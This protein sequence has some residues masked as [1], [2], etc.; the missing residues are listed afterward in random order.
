[1]QYDFLILDYLYHP[2][3][4]IYLQLEAMGCLN[5]NCFVQTIKKS[6]PFILYI[7]KGEVFKEAP[8]FQHT[9]NFNNY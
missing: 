7:N 9:M 4:S 2:I 3:T 5:I 8:P 6:K 1:M